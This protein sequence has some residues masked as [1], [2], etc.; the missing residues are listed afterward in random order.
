[1][2]DGAIIY[3]DTKLFSDCIRA[4]DKI[5]T[6]INQIAH[7]TNAL[8]V[9]LFDDVHQLKKEFERIKELYIELYGSII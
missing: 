5:G 7:N 9:T 2:L 4:L 8:G 3:Q 1:M 6:N